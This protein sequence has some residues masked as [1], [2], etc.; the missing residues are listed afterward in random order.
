MFSDKMKYLKLILCFLTALLFLSSFIVFGDM[1]SDFS[2]DTY[3]KRFTLIAPLQ[4]VP[5][6]QGILDADAVFHT[7][8]KLIGSDTLDPDQQAEEINAAV[9]SGVDGIITSGTS[10]S[11]NLCEAIQ[12][13][14]DHGIPVV[15]IDSDLPNSSRNVYIGSNNYQMGVLS[16]QS[17][18]QET[19]KE[20]FVGIII[21][22]LENPNQKQRILGF[23]DEISQ[24]DTIQVVEILEC[25]SN[26]LEILEK[27]PK[28]LTEFSQI[29]A[30][31][32]A[33]AFT[34][35]V[36]GDIIK[37]RYSSLDLTIVATDDTDT[38]RQHILD[39]T[40]LSSTAQSPYDEGYLSVQTLYQMTGNQPVD[41]YIYTDIFSITQEN[42]NHFP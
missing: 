9:L 40:Y 15:L 7:N 24:Y 12:N 29:N 18:I 41:E 16:A 20:L 17:M 35:V 8:T 37:D 13:A 36:V 6:G 33:E 11:E 19:K 34:S 32:L 3:E 27:V 31:Y 30:L 14:S 38:I 22:D 25:H 1:S 42:L 5:V 23:L 4:W 28:L 2:S 21:S 39:G 10:T 26:Q